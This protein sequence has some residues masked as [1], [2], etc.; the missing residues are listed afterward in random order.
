M[1]DYK[2][3]LRL[4]Y[5][6]VKNH[7]PHICSNPDCDDYGCVMN[8]RIVAAHERAAKVLKEE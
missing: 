8:R 7:R 1:I 5:E 6:A 3:E 4:L 2:E